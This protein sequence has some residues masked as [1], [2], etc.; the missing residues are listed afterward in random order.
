MGRHLIVANQTL[1]GTELE[2]AV[3]SR[4]ADGAIEFFVLVPA[5]PP[6]E[7]PVWEPDDH[8]FD[9]PE[10]SGAATPTRPADHRLHRMIEKITAL[11][12]RAEGTIGDPDPMVAL[13]PVL[14]AEA[15][16]G[17]IVSMLP[18]GLSRWLRM[19]L[20]SRIERT[21]DCPVTTVEA[22]AR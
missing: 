2:A 1:G 19:D 3:A 8:R 18:A 20:A 12:G 9:L 14:A 11:G 16:D 6:G 22:H 15:F 21:V 7:E 4:I 5:T 10:G 13:E 17:I